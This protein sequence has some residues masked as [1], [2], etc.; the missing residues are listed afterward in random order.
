MTF[1]TLLPLFAIFLILGSGIAHA[2][3]LYQMF[4]QNFPQI[5]RLPVE[6]LM[7][8]TEFKFEEA[9]FDDIYAGYRIFIPKGWLQAGEQQIRNTV[10]DDRVRGE[11][12]RFY[13]NPIIDERGTLTI[14]TYDLRFNTNAESWLIDYLIDFGY[15]VEGIETHG[16]NHAQAVA[17]LLDEE[18]DDLKDWIVARINGTRVFLMTFSVP[19]RLFNGNQNL[20]ASIAHTFDL[21][22]EDPQ[23]DF[24]TLEFILDE[25]IVLNYSKDWSLIRS[26]TG[27]L[28]FSQIKLLNLGSQ[29][30][31]YD[32]IITFNL[33]QNE[34][35]QTSLVQDL[36]RTKKEVAELGFE[37]INKFEPGFEL[38]YPVGQTL[39]I[40]E[41]H[42]VRNIQSDNE[43]F[44]A[45]ISVIKNDDHTYIV[46]ML[47]PNQTQDFAKW[48]E[49]KS[50]FETVIASIRPF[51]YQ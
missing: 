50:N 20:I 30:K 2:A 36:D 27:R 28:D 49:N 14:R 25:F 7:E 51:Y 32:G 19:L 12:A 35:R 48:V 10:R 16:E 11:V 40:F 8:M 3:G 38:D 17:V 33:F 42:Q 18:G 46:H 4:R 23:E 47:T 21:L 45:W 29:E 15:S 22:E 26:R 24:G 41:T 6:Q 31:R 44:E 13:S 34:A 9:P 5:E 39:T 43:R 37:F 1:R